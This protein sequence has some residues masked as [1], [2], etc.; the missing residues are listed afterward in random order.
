MPIRAFVLWLV[1]VSLPA[2]AQLPQV[3]AFN[4]DI[5]DN[6][7]MTSANVY[8]WDTKTNQEI[9]ASSADWAL[10]RQKVGK[11]APWDRCEIRDGAF[12]DFN[13]EGPRGTENFLDQVKAAVKRGHWQG[14]SWKAF[15]DAMQ[16][17]RA[18]EWT[19]LITAREHAPESIRRGLQYLVT[20]GYLPAVPAA[21]HIYPVLWSGLPKPFQG[22]D[23]SESKA[24]VMFSLLDRL[25]KVPVPADAKLVKNR[26]GKG[27]AKLH[28]WGFSDDDFG[29]FSTA[30]ERLAPEVARGRWPHVKIV[31]FFD[32]LNHPTEKPRGVV[33]R[34]DGTLRPTMPVEG[35]RMKAAPAL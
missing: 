9:A 25:E 27:E 15:A 30:A 17:P 24:L 7:L 13:V 3:Q 16:D 2:T 29:N 22:K 31:L 19:S 8:L 18:R 12:R 21:D 14:P 11:V 20:L 26:E 33:I 4:F 23:T 6:I 1:L 35:T 32:G 34:P 28:L 10:V 5:D